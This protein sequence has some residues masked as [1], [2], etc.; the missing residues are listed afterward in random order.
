ME[1]SKFIV[2]PF[3]ENSIYSQKVLKILNKGN[4]NLNI[5]VI[6]MHYRISHMCNFKNI[7]LSFVTNFEVAYLNPNI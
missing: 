5:D 2:F 4:L 1:L 6:K 3:L 7:F